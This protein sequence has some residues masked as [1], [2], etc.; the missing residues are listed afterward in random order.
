[1]KLPED[2]GMKKD[3]KRPEYIEISGKVV[4]NAALCVFGLIALGAVSV[5]TPWQELK[6]ALVLPTDTSEQELLEEIKAMNMT[7]RAI[8][9]KDS[10]VK[11]GH[12]YL[13]AKD[14][15]G[16]IPF[17]IHENTCVNG[18]RLIVRLKEKYRGMHQPQKGAVQVVGV[19]AEK[20]KSIYSAI[21]TVNDAMPAQMRNLSNDMILENETAFLT[22]QITAGENANRVEYKLEC[23]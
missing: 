6:A 15:D 17:M 19:S 23:Y 10:T 1:M 3:K 7:L 4:R 12:E 14:L 16:S 18:A 8:Q 20:Q 5:I 22:Y 2:F 11:S 9:Q 13:L 21:I